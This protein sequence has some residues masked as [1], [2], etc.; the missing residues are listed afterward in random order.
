MDSNF[1]FLFGRSHVLVSL[2]LQM[3]FSTVDAPTSHGFL[4]VKALLSLLM[5]M[6]TYMCM[7]ETR[8]ALA[9]L[10]SLSSTTNL[11]FLLHMH[12]PTRHTRTS[13]RTRFHVWKKRMKGS[14]SR[15]F[16]MLAVHA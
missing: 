6:E 11:S 2:K 13:W 3:L 9:I 10:H 7:K 4:K 12:G 5:P 15:R 16:W 8:I 1:E 14:R